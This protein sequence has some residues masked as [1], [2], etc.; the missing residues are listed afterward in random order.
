MTKIEPLAQRLPYAAIRPLIG[1]ARSPGFFLTFPT[2]APPRPAPPRP[3]DA[4]APDDKQRHACA[5]ARPPAALIRPISRSKFFE[6]PARL[7]GLTLAPP[8]RH[9]RAT[10]A[11]PQLSFRGRPGRLA[12]PPR[13]RDSP[14]LFPPRVVPF[15]RERRRR[16]QRRLAP[17]Q[18]IEP[19]GY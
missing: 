1:W 3:S 9:P 12:P 13:P 16:A 8:S 5:H 14:E 10:P 7:P 15:F 6:R 4:K 2:P 18:S 19:L 17:L 11:P